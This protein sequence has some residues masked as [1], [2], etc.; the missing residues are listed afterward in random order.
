METKCKALL[1]I[2]REW[3]AGEM[4]VGRSGPKHNLLS[5]L[6]LGRFAH[7]E[8]DTVRMMENQRAHAGFRIHHDTLGQ[9]HADL[10]RLEELPDRD[11]VFQIGA[12]GVA[13]A[14][15]LAAVARSKSL[16]HSQL[17]LIREA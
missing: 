1:S 2:Y 10:F 6:C 9:L 13:K 14:V 7:R 3:H 8:I 15:P 5:R 11:L 4:F 17:L 16:R 12:R